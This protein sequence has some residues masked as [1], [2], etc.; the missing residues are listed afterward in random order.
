MV[1]ALIVFSTC[2]RIPV[3]WESPTAKAAW[4]EKEGPKCNFRLQKYGCSY[5]AYLE[6]NPAMKKWGELN[7]DMA[8]KESIKLQSID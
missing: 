7:P 3:D 5:D 1:A 4:E 8:V 2:D 6:T